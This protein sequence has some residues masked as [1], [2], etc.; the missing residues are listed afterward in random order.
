MAN[1][2]LPTEMLS[3]QELEYDHQ[4]EQDLHTGHRR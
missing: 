1:R 2:R 4:P 3:S